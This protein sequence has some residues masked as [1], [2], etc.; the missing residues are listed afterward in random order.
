MTMKV[1]GL[2]NQFSAN[3]FV[4]VN[5]NL[6]LNVNVKAM[7]FRHRKQ[8]LLERARHVEQDARRVKNAQAQD[9]MR[10]L[11]AFYR[12]TAEELEDSGL[13]ERHFLS[14]VFADQR[15]CPQSKALALND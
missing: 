15:L 6:N 14:L 3:A 5:L 12:E 4:L 10:A 13:F 7:D 8:E 11:A 2:R 9:I 1:E